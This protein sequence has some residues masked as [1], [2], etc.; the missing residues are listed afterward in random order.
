MASK[1]SITGKLQ[2]FSLAPRIDKEGNVDYEFMLKFT[3]DDAQQAVKWAI[4][5]SGQ[6]GELEFTPSQTSIL[7]NER[8]QKK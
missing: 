6:F 4:I 2:K 5:H 8:L 7:D 1:F 3:V